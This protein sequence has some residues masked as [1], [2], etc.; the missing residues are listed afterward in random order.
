MGVVA[1]F[2]VT[3]TEQFQ[4]SGTKVNMNAVSAT[5]DPNVT[6]DEDKRFFEATPQAQLTM[7][8]KNAVAAE[9][10]QPGDKHYVTFERAES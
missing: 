10:F 7:H 4:Y 3:S 6:N 1:K 5:D 9:Q 2:V 8:I